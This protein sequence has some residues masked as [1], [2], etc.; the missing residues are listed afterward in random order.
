MIAVPPIQVQ[1]GLPFDYDLVWEEDGTPVDMTGWTG[2]FTVK[3]HFGDD[4]KL[5][6]ATPAL[7]AA[8]EI[9]IDLTADQIGALPFR[10]IR[11]PAKIGFYQ[12]TVTDGTTGQVFQGELHASAA[13]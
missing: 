2:T 8:G 12:I 5:L 1:Q 13:L 10:D 3:A 4:T 7:G 11:G 9:T 6:T